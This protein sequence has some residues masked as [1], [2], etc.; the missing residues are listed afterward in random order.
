MEKAELIDKLYGCVFNAASAGQ[1]KTFMACKFLDHAYSKYTARPGSKQMKFVAVM[2]MPSCV[3]AQ[4][5]SVME[6]NFPGVRVLR[7]SSDLERRRQVLQD[8]LAADDQPLI[9]CATTSIVETD[10][11]QLRRKGTR[12]PLFLGV[13]SSS[14]LTKVQEAT[15]KGSSKPPGD[16]NESL[17][18][19]YENARKQFGYVM[20]DE[21]HHVKNEESWRSV[22]MKCLTS[23]IAE[24]G[25]LTLC[26]GTP[27]VNDAVSDILAQLRL[28]P[29]LVMSDPAIMSTTPSLALL[30]LSSIIRAT[31]APRMLALSPG[32]SA[33]ELLKVSHPIDDVSATAAF[34][35]GLLGLEKTETD[36]G[37]L[38]SAAGG[39]GLAVELR[40]LTGAAFEPNSGYLGLTARVPSVEAALL[41]AE[42]AEAE[43][44]APGFGCTGA[45]QM[46]EM[47]MVCDK[48]GDAGHH[49]AH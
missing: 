27:A 39:A 4:N 45:H 30:S 49:G 6:E 46:G 34:Y 42:K 11:S 20:I 3:F 35:Q 23:Q 40:T 7:Y 32:T 37:V 29:R 8:A 12:S 41:A 1:G 17:V 44:A 36:C 9:I 21:S 28:C 25:R 16:L 14:Y 24:W 31:P 15:A 33:G 18:G 19:L 10:F 43:E 26:S 13:E 22:A 5:S 47:W 48:H 38:L 2:V